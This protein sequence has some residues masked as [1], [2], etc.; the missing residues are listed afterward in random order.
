ML[1]LTR[2]LGQSIIIGD[3][4]VIFTILGVEGCQVKIGVEADKSIPVHREEVYDRIQ[5]EK[6][7]EGNR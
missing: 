2:P 1:V 5:M 3:K 6:D 7:N 4:E